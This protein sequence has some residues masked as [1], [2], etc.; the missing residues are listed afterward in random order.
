MKGI[1]WALGRGSYLSLL[2]HK[3]DG[4][5]SQLTHYLYWRCA[6]C[7][8][9]SLLVT[10]LREIS[11]Q[12]LIPQRHFPKLLMKQVLKRRTDTWNDF[13]FLCACLL[14]LCQVSRSSS[15]SIYKRSL[16]SLP[17]VTS[18]AMARGSTSAGTA[19][20]AAS[21]QRSSHSAT[22][23]SPTSRSWSTH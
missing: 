23:P 18:C 11:Q 22:A 12:L 5:C 3:A 19:N 21:V 1:H 14:F 13:V 9:S 16:S 17:W 2:S 4:L 15:L 10:A 8:P 7:T 20:V 6:I